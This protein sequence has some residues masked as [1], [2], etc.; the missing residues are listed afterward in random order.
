MNTVTRTPTRSFITVPMGSQRFALSAESVV[1]LVAA[2][3]P[4]TFPHQTSWISGVIVRR[5]RVIPVCEPAALLGVAPFSPRFYLLAEWTYEGAQGCCA[6][7][8]SGECELV[9]APLETVPSGELEKLKSPQFASG[10]M[11]VKDG[12]LEVIDLGRLIFSNS[13]SQEFLAEVAP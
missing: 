6:I 5:N 1:E 13:A 10:F 12:Q 4:Q 3:K 9:A 11:S 2:Q 7:P 8:V